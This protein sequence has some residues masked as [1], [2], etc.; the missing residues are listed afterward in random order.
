MKW[1]GYNGR[2]YVPAN[3]LPQGYGDFFG[4]IDGHALEISYT[5]PTSCLAFVCIED[6]VQNQSP[7]VCEGCLHYVSC[8]LVGGTE[9]KEFKLNGSV[10]L[11]KTPFELSRFRS[12]N[13]QVL[14]SKHPA[15]FDWS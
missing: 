13:Q 14:S 8:A 5:S 4:V 1:M 15:N 3:E 11:L 7:S 12:E 6:K 10:Q 2:T 9:R